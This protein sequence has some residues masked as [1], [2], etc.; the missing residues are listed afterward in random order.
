MDSGT[1]LK[2]C[3]A[4]VNPMNMRAI[5]TSAG[6]SSPVPA[7]SIRYLHSSIFE[8]FGSTST[9]ACLSVQQ[10][11]QTKQEKIPGCL[12]CV[13]VYACVFE[14]VRARAVEHNGFGSCRHTH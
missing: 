14:S 12:A 10:N 11:A 13:R 5:G 6:A 7:Q 3:A 2:K 1:E 4:F 8:N 9:C